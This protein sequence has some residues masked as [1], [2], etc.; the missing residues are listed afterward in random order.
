MDGVKW[1]DIVVTG[2]F[3][4][5]ERFLQVMAASF[6]YLDDSLTMVDL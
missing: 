2:S 6:A 3:W 1:S 4:H 5:M